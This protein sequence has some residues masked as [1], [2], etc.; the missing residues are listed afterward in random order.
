[1]C[2]DWSRHKAQ[3][4]LE[5]GQRGRR[6]PPPAPGRILDKDRRGGQT[7]AGGAHVYWDREQGHSGRKAAQWYYSRVSRGFLTFEGL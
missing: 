1:M 6:P 4:G 2:R 5:E 3:W 7:T